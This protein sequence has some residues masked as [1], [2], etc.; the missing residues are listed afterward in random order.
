MNPTEFLT[1][2]EE[3]RRVLA[4]PDAKTND[5]LA[6]LLKVVV[7]KREIIARE[8]EALVRELSSSAPG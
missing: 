4:D 3:C 2:A 6:S 8:A 1:H 5:R 7:G